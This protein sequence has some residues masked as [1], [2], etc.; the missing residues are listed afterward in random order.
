MAT[1]FLLEDYIQTATLTANPFAYAGLP[2]TNL[3]ELSKSLVSRIPNSGTGVIE[4]SAILAI[5]KDINCIVIAG[6]NLTTNTVIQLNFYS[7][8]S[9]TIQIHTE[10][11]SPSIELVTPHDTSMLVLPIWLQLIN[12]VNAISITFSNINTPY[13]QIYRIMVGKYIES[14]IGASKNSV[15][16]YKDPSE[17]YRTESGTLKTD[18]KK[19][20][21]VMS[22]DLGTINEGERSILS[23][24]LAKV[25]KQKAFYISVF[26]SGCS[27]NYKEIDYSGI[28]K[29][30]KIPTY[31]EFAHNYYS[32]KIEVEEI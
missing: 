2:I 1:R 24:S 32:S 3:R 17:Q 23:R 10:T 11:I 5:S 30:T 9:K 13:L 31:T 15:W 6:H 29:L 26:K 7:D 27:G 19:P 18:Y 16:S 14:T 28:V 12:N 22:F 4:I 21:K 8:T 25:G 20:Y